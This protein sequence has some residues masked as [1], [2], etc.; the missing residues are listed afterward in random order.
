MNDSTSKTKPQSPEKIML[1]RKL[2]KKIIVSRYVDICD[3]RQVGWEHTFILTWQAFR[4]FDG[5]NRMEL[6]LEI[7]LLSNLLSHF[8]HSVLIRKFR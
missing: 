7:L 4:R 5:R 6:L 2:R 1:L 8:L 3:E